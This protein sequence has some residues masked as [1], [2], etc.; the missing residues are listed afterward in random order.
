MCRH[1]PPIFRHFDSQ[2]LFR[3]MK[4]RISIEGLH[5]RVTANQRDFVTA[6]CN[7]ATIR[8]PW[9]SLAA[10]AFGL[11]LSVPGLAQVKYSFTTIDVPKA[12]ATAANG[13]S[14]NAI[15]GQFDDADENTHGFV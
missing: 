3:R 5:K 9:K 15:A 12:T 10:V 2:H 7:Q 13:N 6:Q 11:L 8:K 4:T 1:L 14:T